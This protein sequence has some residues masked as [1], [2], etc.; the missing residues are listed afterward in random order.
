VKNKIVYV[1]LFLIAFI[2]T[3]GGVVY[4]NSIY[5]N[6]FKYD[7]SQAVS[8]DTAQ[9]KDSTKTMN[10]SIA[11]VHTDTVKALNPVNSK[12]SVLIAVKHDSTTTDSSKLQANVNKPAEIPVVDDKSFVNGKS[13]VDYTR[14]KPDSSYIVW[15]KQTAKMYESMDPKKAAKIIQS[16]SDNIARDII[17][18]MKQKKAAE[19][20]SELNPDTANRITRAK[21]NAF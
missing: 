19:I 11:D 13:T 14:A 2:F 12:D 21:S 17:Y 18:S 10:A 4:L 7:F 1:F 5:K 16:Y 20:L 9:V 3:T 8:A 15:M 6:I